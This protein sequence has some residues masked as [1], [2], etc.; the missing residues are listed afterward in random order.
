MGIFLTFMAFVASEIMQ[1]CTFLIIAQL[2]GIVLDLSFHYNSQNGSYYLDMN[3]F[4]PT[5]QWGLSFL[6]KMIFF[7]MMAC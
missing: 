6:G 1:H 5:G 3:P 4:M 2:T 7:Y